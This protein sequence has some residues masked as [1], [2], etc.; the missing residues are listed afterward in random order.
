MRKNPSALHHVYDGVTM[1]AIL[2]LIYV[3][4]YMTGL[5]SVCLS[6]FITM[7]LITTNLIVNYSLHI[8]EVEKKNTEML[9]DELLRLITKYNNDI[10][11]SLSLCGID[12]SD[13][14][15][16]PLIS[17]SE[18]HYDK[19][20]IIRAKFSDYNNIIHW[21]NQIYSQNIPVLREILE[22]SQNNTNKND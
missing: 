16:P 3:S 13:D 1:N 9:E 8:S 11:E 5:H 18:I 19:P 22:A 4:A 6:S 17:A 14:D 10:K 21:S 15:M 12:E 20:E 2:F 7:I